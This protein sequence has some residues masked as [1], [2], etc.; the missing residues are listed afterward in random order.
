M[1]VEPEDKVNVQMNAEENAGLVMDVGVEI[2][3]LWFK[4]FA[5]Q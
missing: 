5:L 3:L 4:Q 1:K 2:L